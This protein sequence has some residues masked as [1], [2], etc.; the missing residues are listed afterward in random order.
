MR[1]TEH[2]TGVG[3]HAAQKRSSTWR[4]CRSGG[5]RIAK[6]YAVFGKLLQI[7]R[8]H[9]IAVWLDVPTSVVRM[10]KHD[11]NRMILLHDR[12]IKDLI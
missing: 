6:H 8:R 2:A 11:V 12:S 7:R 4:T 9:A 5:K 10:K 3:P 1:Q